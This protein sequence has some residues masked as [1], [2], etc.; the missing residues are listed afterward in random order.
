MHVIHVQHFFFFTS[1]YRQMSVVKKKFSWCWISVGT[2]MPRLSE[3][4]RNR[5]L[6]MLMVVWTK[7]NIATFDCSGS[8]VTRL[9]QHVHQTGNVK[10]FPMPGHPRPR[11]NTPRQVQQMMVNHIRD[12][13]DSAGSGNVKSEIGRHGWIYTCMGRNYTTQQDASCCLEPQ[14]ERQCVCE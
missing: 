4:E 2:V 1:C 7:R 8:T 13:I 12:R 9:E 11:V 5:A 10:D 14:H 6:R 3:N